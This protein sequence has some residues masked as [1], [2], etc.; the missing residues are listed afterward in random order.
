MQIRQILSWSSYL[1]LAMLL[2]TILSLVYSWG[3]VAEANKK[4]NLTLE[5]RQTIFELIILRDDYLLH[6]QALR[7]RIQYKAKTD[8]LMKLLQLAAASFTQP[9]ERQLLAEMQKNIPGI[10]SIFAKIVENRQRDNTDA[11]DKDN[12]LEWEKRLVGQLALKA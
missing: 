12:F 9:R 4:E 3:E 7:A 6:H 8:N 1:S 11:Q 5:I 10:V 2:L